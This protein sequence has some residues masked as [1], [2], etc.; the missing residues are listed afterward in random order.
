MAVTQFEWFSFTY[1]KEQ[2]KRLTSLWINLFPYK[3][4]FI[5]YIFCEHIYKKNWKMG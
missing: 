3:I 2:K 1:N 5:Y 4:L